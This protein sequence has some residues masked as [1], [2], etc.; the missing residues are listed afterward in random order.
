MGKVKPKL[1]DLFCGA[2]GCSVGY[3]RAGF[4]VVGVDIEAHPDYPFPM[5]VAD[6]MEVLAVPAFL[7]GFHV[8]AASPPC[9]RFS[10]ITP[11][12]S[13][14]KHPDLLTPTRDALKAWGGVYIIENVGG[15][16]RHMDN[17]VKVC[18]SAFGL[19]VR[20]HRFFEA[21]AW[22]L[23]T[24]CFHAAQGEPL[25][26][27]GKHADPKTY[28]RP[29]QGTSRG[30]RARSLEEAQEAMGIDWMTDWDDITD[31][32]PPAFTEFLGRQLIET[33][34]VAA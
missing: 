27:Y 21:N 9:P 32:I 18:G 19:A 11:A 15:A 14:D 16:A 25:G 8:V 6:A 33:L 1:L 22:L 2:G 17:P 23:P 34:E 7:D 12:A 5:V 26:V 3:A 13:R 10:T 24:E 4:D 30:V 29:V 28:R 31:A 20:R